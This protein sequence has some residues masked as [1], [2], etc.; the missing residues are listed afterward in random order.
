MSTVTGALEQA[1]NVFLVSEKF[2]LLRAD[3]HLGYLFALF[4][5]AYFSLLLYITWGEVTC[6]P[7]GADITVLLTAAGA[8]DYKDFG[9]YLNVTC[10]TAIKWDAVW[11]YVMT[12]IFMFITSIIMYNNAYTV[13]ALNEMLDTEFNDTNEATLFLCR[14]NRTYVP[15]AL[16]AA[17]DSAEAHVPFYWGMVH[18]VMSV[19]APSLFLFKE[20]SVLRDVT[21]NMI[22][23]Y[24]AYTYTKVIQVPVYIACLAASFGYTYG[25]SIFYAILTPD[26]MQC[27]RSL[28]WD[29]ERTGTYQCHFHSE[30]LIL[31]LWIFVQVIGIIMSGVFLMTLVNALLVCGAWRRHCV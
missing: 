17:E 28:K 3:T 15:R 13:R 9:D 29:T 16:K 27:D 2:T 25:I 4:L 14:M 6:I 22:H 26:V 8:N 12:T 19:F 31:S 21:P 30:F 1:L 20:Q 18:Y 11:L 7:R 23:A 5:S 24:A 10:A